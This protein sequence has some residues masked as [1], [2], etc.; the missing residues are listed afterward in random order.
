MSQYYSTLKNQ[1]SVLSLSPTLFVNPYQDVFANTVDNNGARQRGNIIDSA[2]ASTG[3][4]IATAGTLGSKPIYNGEGWYFEGGAQMTTGTNTDYNFIHD[5][6]NFDI[7]CTVFIC[8]TAST[9][10]QRAFI[11]NNGFSTSARGIL[12]RANATSGNNQLAC[13]VGN[14]TSSMI[15]LTANG[16]LTVNATNVI[17]I[18]RSGATARMF[19]NG[20]QVATQTIVASS[21]VG[22]AGGVMTFATI[23]GQT[24][25]IYLKDVVIFNRAL[26]TDEVAKMNSRTFASITPTPINIY[27]LAGDSNSAGRG[28]NSAIAPDLTGVMANTICPTFSASFDRT[29][30]IEKLQLGKNQTIP[31]ENPT[32]QHGAEMRFCKSMSAASEVMII[33]QGIGS[34]T[35]FRKND[36]GLADYNVNTLL[37]SYARWRTYVLPVALN[38][39][40]HSQRR[41]PVF[42]GFIWTL[43]A[44]DAIYGA[45]GA[46]WTRSGTTLTVTS[47]AHGFTTPNTI[48]FYDSSDLA[49]I[50]TANYVVTRVDANT[51]TIQVPNAG[52]TSGTVSFS[53]GYYF[54]QNLTDVINGTIDYLTS[55]IKNEITNGTGYT[56][57]KL[58]L[59]IVQTRSGGSNFKAN[60]FAQVVA[61]EQSVGND[62]LTDN[63]SRTSNVLGSFVQS[64]E[65]LPMS[66]TIHYTTAGYDSL[67]QLEAD[68]F[69]PFINE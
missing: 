44:N 42:R 13:N 4:A 20:T 66:D 25:N 7:W 49:T 28:T 23:L 1:F 27:M 2:T 52:A 3:Q 63:P 29:S 35:I 14:G 31:S 57:N 45:V 69:L 38:D 8:P 16:A 46:S 15:T 43:G 47:T 24:A 68:Y 39:L 32:T 60:S 40:V 51:F 9:T 21:G 56:V 62:Y 61:A 67:G 48:G 5:G 41:T 33:K 64:T 55:T 58:R 36:G 19:V 22:A 6:S 30:Y 53:G 54:K 18:T 34:N 59:F 11:C 10:Y 17:R 50:P 37:S 12:L 26:T 65:S